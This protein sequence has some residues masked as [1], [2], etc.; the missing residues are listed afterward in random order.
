MP[1]A[2]TLLLLSALLLGTAPPARAQAGGA[3]VGLTLEA[4]AATSSGGATAFVA[5]SEGQVEVRFRQA[6]SAAYALRA[7]LDWSRWRAELGLQVVPAALF[8]ELPDGGGVGVG[9]QDATVVELVPR[10]GYRLAR[11]SAGGSLRLLAGPTIQVWSV[12]DEDS[13]VTIAVGVAVQAE[14]PLAAR[15]RL[16]ARGGVTAGPSMFE[17]EDPADGLFETTG[18]MRWQGGVGL[19]W[20]LRP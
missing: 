14:A 3:R 1:T 5:V 4:A 11:T 16:V 9:G 15:L 6:A 18:V 13:R 2:S 10:L 12:T 20:L 8:A 7:D 19:R 17:D